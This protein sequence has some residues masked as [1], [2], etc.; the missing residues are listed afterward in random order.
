MVCN[1]V[2]LLISKKKKQKRVRKLRNP[3]AVL[4]QRFWRFYVLSNR[5][6]NTARRATTQ[7]LFSR[8]TEKGS[9]LRISRKR[10]FSEFIDEMQS[11]VLASRKNFSQQSPGDGKR[12][13]NLT[14]H[15]TYDED[16][17]TPSSPN[18]CC[19][20]SVLHTI[21]DNIRPQ[22]SSSRG[23]S[24]SSL[25]EFNFE[26]I[27]RR[28]QTAI[29]FIHRCSVMIAWRNFKNIR[30]PFVN[31]EDLM[32]KNNKQHVETI[33]H[34]EEIDS[35]LQMFTEKFDEYHQHHQHPTNSADIVTQDVV[36]GLHAHINGLHTHIEN[37]QHSVE[38]VGQLDRTVD[39]LRK[40]VEDLQAS[41]RELV[42]LLR[43]RRILERTASSVSL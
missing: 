11:E 9:G 26:H 23:V 30:N 20:K 17:E 24:K 6:N 2:P 32:E 19:L 8:I 43:E 12:T 28:Y 31:M 33:A 42:S 18:C 16:A 22:R 41:N 38:R 13:A 27:P 39:L 3:A 21:R 34:F 10:K 14:N 7:Y 35:T 29:Q 5:D 37:V 1:F 25:G 15:I 36:E 4:I 40:Q